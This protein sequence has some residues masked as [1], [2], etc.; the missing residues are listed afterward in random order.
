MP[1]TLVTMSISWASASDRMS[2][3]GSCARR[4]V[5]LMIRFGSAAILTACAYVF[6]DSDLA[7][8]ADLTSDSAHCQLSASVGLRGKCSRAVQWQAL[9]EGKEVCL[10]GR[11]ERKEPK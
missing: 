3:H 4:S 9:R 8:G 11:E 6:E 2:T 5:S 10:E 1:G 7:Q